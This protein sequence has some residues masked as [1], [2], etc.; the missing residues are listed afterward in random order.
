MVRSGNDCSKWIKINLCCWKIIPDGA[1]YQCIGVLSCTCC[2]AR[3]TY[4]PV[5]DPEAVTYGDT[6]PDAH[7]EWWGEELWVVAGGQRLLRVEDSPEVW[8]TRLVVQLATIEQMHLEGNFLYDSKGRKVMELDVENMTEAELQNVEA[9]PVLEPYDYS[10]LIP[11]EYPPIRSAS[12]HPGPAA[13]KVEI[14]IEFIENTEIKAIDIVDQN[15]AIVKKA[16]GAPIPVKIR[17]NFRL[18]IDVSGLAP[19]PYKVIIQTTGDQK[20]LDWTRQ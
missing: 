3:S 5:V 4:T 17:G 9:I 14:Q 12:L 10:S 18:E 11:Y 20:I 13:D 7:L 19:G 16:I 15:N 6:L 8:N 1:C 2:W